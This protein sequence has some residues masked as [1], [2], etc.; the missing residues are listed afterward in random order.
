MPSYSSPITM[1]SSRPSARPKAYSPADLARRFQVSRTTLFRWEREERIP[2]ADRDGEGARVY[3]EGHVRAIEKHL[4]RVESDQK[5]RLVKLV[6]GDYRMVTD[7]DATTKATIRSFLVGRNR[8]SDAATL[9]GLAFAGRLDP[10][11]V[12][13]LIAE[14]LRN[15]PG[16]S[17]RSDVWL[18]LSEL[19]R[20]AS[21]LREISA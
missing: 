12:R 16:S 7:Y 2:P 17:I 13:V 15:P 19:E 8:P 21:A 4:R 6:G 20:G 1:V 3:S 18:I 14:A 11:G 10:A 5:R 9:R